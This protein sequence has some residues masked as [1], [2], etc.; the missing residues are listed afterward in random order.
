[1]LSYVC[2]VA[3]PLRIAL[4]PGKGVCA[5]LQLNAPESG[6]ARASDEAGA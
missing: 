3:A 6:E 5:L 4:L 2:R 1:M